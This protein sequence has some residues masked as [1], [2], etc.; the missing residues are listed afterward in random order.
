MC[1]CEGKSF[2]L[3]VLRLIGPPLTLLGNVATLSSVALKK[4]EKKNKGRQVSEAERV[5]AVTPMLAIPHLNCE[6][7][8][9]LE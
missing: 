5:R 4:K 8:H 7:F 2:F 1:S 6:M 9:L 3:A